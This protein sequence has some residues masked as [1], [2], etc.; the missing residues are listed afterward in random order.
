MLGT[1]RPDEFV[2]GSGADLR[3]RMDDP[4]MDL[5]LVTTLA[6]LESLDELRGGLMGIWPD[7]R[8]RRDGP[9]ED[10]F[11]VVVEPFDEGRNRGPGRRAK[12]GERPG[13]L[14]A[15]DLIIATEFPDQVLY[16]AGI[17]QYDAK[18]YGGN[19]FKKLNVRFANYTRL[20]PHLVQTR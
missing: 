9:K 18:E 3:E 5:V 1:K 17:C 7:F 16:L 19:S 14:S 4:H 11:L 8:K 6:P 2:Y 15:L 20:C 12:Q 13:C 10:L